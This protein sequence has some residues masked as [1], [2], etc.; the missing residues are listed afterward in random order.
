MNLFEELQKKYTLEEI[1]ESYVFPVTLTPKEQRES[2][3][4]LRAARLEIL[5]KMTPEERFHGHLLGLRYRM[6]DVVKLN[7]KSKYQ[8]SFPTALQEYLQFS[9]KKPADFA[10]EIALTTKQLN[11][12]VKGEKAP[13][14]GLFHRLE[15]H[16]GGTIPAMLWWKLVAQKWEHDIQTDHETRAREA[17][18]VK[19][20][21]SFQTSAV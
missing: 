4:L 15:K 2:N 14:I 5:R 19:N 6:E 12:L 16:A 13:D 3:E 10:A 9:E 7:G 17:S 21:L 18:K 1:A 11:Q 20:G 8:Y